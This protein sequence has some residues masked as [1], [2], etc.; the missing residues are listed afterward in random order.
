M[1][2]TLIEIAKSELGWD[3]AAT[4]AAKPARPIVDVFNAEIRGFSK[5]K[6]AKA[7]LRWTRGHEAGDLSDDEQHQWKKLIDAIN[8][9][10]K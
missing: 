8:A 6:L 1:R 5:Y 4:A 2:S 3:I 7:F 10:L 9:A